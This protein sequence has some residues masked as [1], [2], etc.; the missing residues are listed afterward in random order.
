MLQS[1]S[2]GHSFNGSAYTSTLTL[3]N[4]VLYDITNPFQ[5]FQGSTRIFSLGSGVINVEGNLTV[6]GTLTTNNTVINTY[7]SGLI[8]L[9][10]GNP[11]DSVDIGMYGE[12]VN[13]ATT[14]TGLVRD[15]SDPRKSWAIFNNYLTQPTTVVNG[16]SP[17]G[18]ANLD[19]LKAASY[20]AVPSIAAA[21]GFAFTAALDSGI[22]YFGGTI[23]ISL[24]G[25]S[26]L[27]I[28]GSS[29]LT[30]SILTISATPDSSSTTDATAS[31]STLGGLSVA[32]KI[33]SGSI[34]TGAI[35][36]T[37]VS[38]TT[39]NS[40]SITT[41]NFGTSSM[42]ASG[43]ATI[44]T[45]NVN[46]L[47][48]SGSA[49]LTTVTAQ[50]ITTVNLTVTGATNIPAVTSA[51]GN[52]TT[53]T[54]GTSNLGSTTITGTLNVSNPGTNSITGTTNLQTVNGSVATFTQIRATSGN[55][56]S[57][58]T[59]T[60]SAIS[61]AGGLSVTA[62]A[63]IGGNVTVGGNL[64]VVGS[65]ISTQG[66]NKITGVETGTTV[67]LTVS[68]CAIE[69]TNAG[70]VTVNL[71]PFS[72]TYKGKEYYILSYSGSVILAPNGADFLNGVNSSII[73][74]GVPYAKIYVL[75]IETGWWTF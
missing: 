35:T 3:N 11:A 60:N 69:C 63:N 34:A 22:Y 2:P 16:G 26:K 64:V 54:A 53:L 57:S 49:G 48:V 68:N 46:S 30:P 32:K 20:A 4:L 73:I 51:N 27:A 56:S 62:N 10:A 47:T 36:G 13:G 6:S 42:T 70:T 45:A 15:S 31:I 12:Y 50:D 58:S 75:G 24:S 72:A 66:S 74:S 52:F 14:Y 19:N 8:H 40:V 37:S 7:S 5:I 9:A 59:D 29:L 44:G 41:T 67:S 65:T 21:P 23:G 18:D 61:T 25:T 39:I 38:T 55:T 43:T 17:I 28:S 71:P 1:F 33:N